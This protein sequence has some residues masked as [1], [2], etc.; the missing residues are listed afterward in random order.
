MKFFLPRW[1]ETVIRAAL[2]GLAVLPMS[3]LLACRSHSSAATDGGKPDAGAAMAGL[4]APADVASPPADA[5]RTASGLASKVLT[6]GTGTDHPAR[7]DSVKVN[8]TG[9]TTDGKMF[10]ST[11]APPRPGRRP[12]PLTL[13]L[14]RVIPGWTEGIPL[15]VV[16]EK[17]RFWIPEDLAYKGRPGAPAG[18]LVFDVELVDIIPGPKPPDDLAAAPPDAE[19]TKDGL[20]SKITQK[21]T[22]TEHPHP[23]DA[24]RLNYSIWQT[25]GKLLDAPQTQPVVRPVTGISSGWTEGL[26][27]MVAGE[28][29]TFWVPAAL[30]TP[31]RPGAQPPSS[32]VTMVIELL[33][34]VP[35]PKTPPDVKAPPKDAIVE[36]DGLATKVLT[37]GTGTVHP[38]R[39][40]NV[41]VNYAGWTTDGKM[42][43]ASFTRGE[44]VTMSLGAVIPGWSEG[45][46]LMVE[47][48]KRRLWIP[49]QLAYKGQPQRPQ[50]MLVFDVELVKIIGPGRGAFGM[51]PPGSGGPVHPMMPPGH[52]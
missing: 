13:S 44:A 42:F 24:V 1:Y 37:K 49:E 50:G 45:I 46:Q 18:M 32:D 25:D 38:T 29:R 6:A 2:V 47:G 34:I 43:D 17:R 33:D 27:L 30:A 28:K 36:K 21:G 15:M 39:T 40:D 14:S 51:P 3:G 4:P 7:Y 16:G 5:S 26:E 41:S 22:G 31:A 9:W 11:V 52:P 35:G 48:E 23:N 12:G 8:Y 10:D 20:A 19:K